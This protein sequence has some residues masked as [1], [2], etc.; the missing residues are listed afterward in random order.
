MATY[1]QRYIEGEHEAVWDELLALGPAIREEP[2]YTDALAVA[3]ETMTRVRYNV[4]LLVARLRTNGYKFWSKEPYIS[5]PAE[6][7]EQI[8]RLE[9][10]V[11]VIPLSVRLWYEIVGRVD[12][13]GTHPKWKI[14]G[15]SSG[16]GFRSSKPFVETYALQIN[17]I[18]NQPQVLRY[19]TEASLRFSED[20][21][22]SEIRQALADPTW[23]NFAFTDPTFVL[24]IVKDAA[25]G[26]IGDVMDV[27]N[28][29]IDGY[30]NP[31]DRQELF[32]KYLRRSFKWGG[33]PGF[34]YVDEILRKERDLM[35]IGRILIIGPRPHYLNFEAGETYVPTAWLAELTQGLLP[36]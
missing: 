33:F 32:V 16:T 24:V 7:D 18:R 26:T 6:I 9:E 30:I 12:L 10:R 14:D 4:E 27:P 29:A 20:A 36:I 22:A 1:L 17:D 23:E 31:G 11:G 19:R 34:A 28:Q 8:V 21:T 25:N 35:G 3:R 15:G 2:L 5:P 13:S